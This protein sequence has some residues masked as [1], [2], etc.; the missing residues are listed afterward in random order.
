MANYLNRLAAAALLL[1]CGSAAA[2]LGNGGGTYAGVD[3]ININPPAIVAQFVGNAQALLN[4]DKTLLAAVG[5]PE[6]AAKAGAEAGALA[7]DATRAQIENALKTQ[8]DSGQA[9]EQQLAKA[10]L[11]DAA[12]LQFSMG[13]GD[14]AR[15]VI[16]YAGMSRDLVEMRKAIKPAGA[17]GASSI[18]LTKAL[19]GAV[20]E[21]GQTLKA[22]VDYAKANNITL[23]PV[24]AEALAQL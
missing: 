20:K 9:L 5:L 21:L 13:I 14:L 22:V 6:L 23:P 18:Y 1:A 24:A 19:P 12:R 8:S 11:D 4:A 10:K 7:P 15:G 16:Q 17:A 2:Q 3:K